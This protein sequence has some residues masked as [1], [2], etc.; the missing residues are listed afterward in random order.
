MATVILALG[1]PA[2]RRLCESELSRVGHSAVAISRPLELIDLERRVRCDVVVVD[3]S[4]LGTASSPGGG[5]ADLDVL[6][7][8]P[9][10]ATVET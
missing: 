7:A 5:P 8:S 10:A 6:H 4:P 2:L 1:D 9:F 3:G